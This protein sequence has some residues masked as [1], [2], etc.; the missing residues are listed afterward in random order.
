MEGS[1]LALP[2]SHGLQSDELVDPLRLRQE[3]GVRRCEDKRVFGEGQG[4]LAEHAGAAVSAHGSTSASAVLACRTV[5]AGQPSRTRLTGFAL[6]A[7]VRGRGA[8]CAAVTRR[9]R[10]AAGRVGDV[11]VTALRKRRASETIG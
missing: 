7:V 10:L 6:D 8:F 2:A 1:A 4:S 11:A 5:G 3:E 9:A